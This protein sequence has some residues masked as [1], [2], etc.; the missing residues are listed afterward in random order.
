[1]QVYQIVKAYDKEI[2]ELPFYIV[3]L[4]PFTQ[5]K[6]GFVKRSDIE[7]GGEVVNVHSFFDLEDGVKFEDI[8]VRV[9]KTATTQVASKLSDFVEKKRFE[10]TDATKV[11]SK[12][13]AKERVFGYLY[14]YQ[15]MTMM[16]AL[17]R[18]RAESIQ[19]PPEQPEF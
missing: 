18:S 11:L 4:A 16:S 14:Q 13:V 19:L 3:W 17:K 12:D 15:T 9:R 1:M 10:V 8:Q 7:N 5:V 2:E 6:V